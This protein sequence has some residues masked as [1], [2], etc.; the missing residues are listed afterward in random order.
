MTAALKESDEQCTVALEDN[1]DLQVS[2]QEEEDTSKATDKNSIQGKNCKGK[3][4]GK[5]KRTKSKEE[6]WK[7]ATEKEISDDGTCLQLDGMSSKTHT[8]YARVYNK[9]DPTIAPK[10]TVGYVLEQMVDDEWKLA[11]KEILEK[12]KHYDVDTYPSAQQL[13]KLGAVWLLNETM[14]TAGDGAHAH[15]LTAK[16]EETT[17]NWID[18][19]VRIY[20]MPE[21]YHAANDVDWSKPCKGLLLQPRTVEVVIGG[22]VPPVSI[23]EAGLPDEKDGVVV[24][25]VRQYML[26]ILGALVGYYQLS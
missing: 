7:D 15:R 5:D 20:A 21:R 8:V 2:L 1:K 4:K 25:K 19:T 24:Y 16:D 13:L 17:P 9:K 11:A 14:W 3:K 12:H 26:L 6:L 23:M 18:F 22:E 10:V